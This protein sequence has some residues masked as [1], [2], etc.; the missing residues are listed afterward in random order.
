MTEETG[1][2][3]LGWVVLIVGLVHLFSSFDYWFSEQFYPGQSLFIFLPSFAIILIG[4]AII[5][6]AKEKPS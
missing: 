6:L 3:S 1:K 2:A 4:V 5:Y